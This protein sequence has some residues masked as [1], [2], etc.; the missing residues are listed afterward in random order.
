MFRFLRWGLLILLICV[1]GVFLVEGQEF[2]TDRIYMERQYEKE[3]RLRAHQKQVRER[4]R[5]SMKNAESHP[6]YMRA[7]Q[8]KHREAVAK[9]AHIEESEKH[10]RVKKL[11]KKKPRPI[12]DDSEKEVARQNE[13]IE[14]HSRSQKRLET[15]REN[16]LKHNK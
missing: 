11:L 9:R 8:E 16:A 10:I 14:S 5:N 6:E 2:S 12:R 3:V 7:V 13:F 4:L 15:H 1:T